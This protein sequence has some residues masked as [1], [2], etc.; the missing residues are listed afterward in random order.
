MKSYYEQ[1]GIVIY[2]GD[3]R[4]YLGSLPSGAVVTDPPYGIDLENHGMIGSNGWSKVAGDT[5]LAAVLDVLTWAEKMP[6]VVFASPWKSWP[7]QWP[8]L[9]VWDKGEAVGGG[10]DTR[11][12]MCV[13]V[14]GVLLVSGGR[15]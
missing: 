15:L 3:C 6:T 8:N 5:D 4:D 9:I 10:G 11:R 12:G 7:G 1:D 13:C 2:H 14:L